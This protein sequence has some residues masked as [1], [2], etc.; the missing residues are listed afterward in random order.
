MPTVNTC[1]FA[2]QKCVTETPT[3]KQ[4]YCNVRN[5]VVQQLR[6]MKGIVQATFHWKTYILRLSKS[7]KHETR[8]TM[9]Q[10]P[11]S[12]FRLLELLTNLV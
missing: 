4:L 6:K 2:S 3:L 8:N 12:L 7:A 9:H 10:T 5:A 1:F 11:N